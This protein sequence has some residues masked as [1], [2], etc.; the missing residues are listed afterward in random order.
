MERLGG[1]VIPVNEVRYS[2]VSKAE[3]LPDT[4]RTLECYADV[5]VLRHPKTGSAELAPVL[6]YSVAPMVLYSISEN[7][8]MPKIK[9]HV[10]NQPKVRSLFYRARQPYNFEYEPL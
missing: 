5:F 2:S 8:S 7:A 10:G 1:S 6:A 3:S 4:I 9:V